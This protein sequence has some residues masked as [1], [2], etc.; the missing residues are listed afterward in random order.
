MSGLLRD[1]FILCEMEWSCL[2]DLNKC[3]FFFTKAIIST[4]ELYL[5]FLFRAPT[6]SIYHL[7]G[8]LLDAKFYTFSTGRTVMRKEKKM[9]FSSAKPLAIF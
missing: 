9:G 6:S 7:R 3:H 5:V 8:S 2:N 1:L 4:E